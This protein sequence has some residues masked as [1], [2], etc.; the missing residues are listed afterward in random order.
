MSLI[1]RFYCFL[2]VEWNTELILMMFYIVSV[3]YL[4]HSG[5]E[6]SRVVLCALCVYAAAGADVTLEKPW[7]A[8]HRC[9]QDCD[10]KWIQMG[11]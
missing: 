7:E 5:V 10:S 11:N 4:E 9:F 6:I 8:L 2:W 3:V 1:L